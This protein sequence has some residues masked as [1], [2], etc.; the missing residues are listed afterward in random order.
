MKRNI[1]ISKIYDFDIED[2]WNAITDKKAMSEWLMPCDIVPKVGSKFQFKTKPTIGFDGIINCEVLEVVE[3]Q[4]L[5]FS[6]NGGPLK[7]T[8]VTFKLTDLNGKTK[9]DFEHKG[10]NG[11]LNR[12]VVRK[13]LSNGWKN[14]ILTILLPKYLSK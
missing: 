13:I 10:F 6:W 11:L 8:I 4:I 14:K 2:V 9:L 5:S 12:L 3:K 1:I 7:G